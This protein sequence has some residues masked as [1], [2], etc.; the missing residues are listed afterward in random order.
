MY[1]DKKME[2]RKLIVA[3]WKMNHTVAESLK[4]FAALRHVIP[5]DPYPEVVIAPPFTALYA[6]E[7]AL[8]GSSFKLGAQNTHWE[9]SGAFTGEIAP[10]FL[11]DLNV[12]YVILGHS[13]RRQY[14]NESN[15]EVNNKLKAV[16]KYKM[17]PIVCVG[18]TDEER[19]AGKTD[20]VIEAQVKEAV[21]GQLKTN[22]TDT[23]WAYEPRW[24]IG[25]GKSASPSQAEE[26]ISEIRMLLEEVFD[27]SV[28]GQMRILYGGS[29]SDKNAKSFVSQ[30]N[31]DG[32]LVGGASLE[33]EHF[34]KIIRSV[35]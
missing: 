8:K 35:E 2:R 28:A 18:E 32:L 26:V 20:A 13:E 24:A 17:T 30:K 23:V 15:E 29:V 6:V 11:K 12:D 9:D 33:A 19:S 34:A 3:N 22:V 4:F 27:K 25:T 14:F 16:L 1:G 31:I 7:E 5:T 10:L 21:G